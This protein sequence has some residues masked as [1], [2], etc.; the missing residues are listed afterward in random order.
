MKRMMFALAVF[1]L[2]LP[3]FGQGVDPLIGTWKINPAKPTSTLPIPKSWT[4]TWSGEGQTPINTAEGVNSQGPFKVVLRHVYDGQPHPTTGSP[5][6]DSTAFGRVGN[7]INAIRFK[8]GKVV[9][10]A[11][12]RIDPGKTYSG[13]VEGIAENGQQYHS[14]LVWDRQ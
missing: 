3:A 4:L 6:Y 1:S 13:H 2:T 8:N 14:D 5:A 12:F 9:E 11:Q 10:V 7:T